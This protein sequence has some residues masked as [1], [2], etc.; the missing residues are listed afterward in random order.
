MIRHTQKPIYFP[1]FT[2]NIIWFYLLWSPVIVCPQNGTAVQ[3]KGWSQVE[4]PP[5]KVGCT[6]LYYW[7][8]P[9]KTAVPFSGQTTWNLTGFPPKRDCGSKRVNFAKKKRSRSISCLI[10]DISHAIHAWSHGRLLGFRCFFSHPIH[11]LRPI[12]LSRPAITGGQS[13]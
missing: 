10:G 2:N 3:K 5:L 7:C 11:C 13:R 9:L 6:N 8:N 1:I 4:A 12:F